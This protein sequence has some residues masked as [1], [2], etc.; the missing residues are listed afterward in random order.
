M[1]KPLCALLLLL[2]VS[3]ARPIKRPP[4]VDNQPCHRRYAASKNGTVEYTE[5]TG[6]IAFCNYEIAVDSKSQIRL[7]FAKTNL[8]RLGPAF[9]DYVLAF[10]GP[11]CMST[12][13]GAVS[14]KRTPTFTSS[15]NQMTALFVRGNIGK[16]FK[17]MY[18][19]DNCGGERN[20]PNGTIS[21]KGDEKVNALCIWRLRV[22]EGKKV[23]LQLRAKQSASVGSWIRL[24][25]GSN[26]SA[27][28]LAYITAQSKSQTYNETSTSNVMMVIFSSVNGFPPEE[29]RAFY[30]DGTVPT[31]TTTTTTSSET[32]ST[33]TVKTRDDEINS[34]PTPS[35]A[36]KDNVTEIPDHTNSWAPKLTCKVLAA[37]LVHSAYYAFWITTH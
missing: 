35:G 25:D 10:D 32:N 18:S 22:G 37:V 33:S 29:F 4:S 30:W 1:E 24:L 13:I 12:R 34:V 28:E 27:R 23:H 8:D 6:N 21:F 9:V 5:G 7:E 11:D 2:G 31:T 14:G 3:S 17:A 15:G 26:C 36:F 16:V 20:G 19:T